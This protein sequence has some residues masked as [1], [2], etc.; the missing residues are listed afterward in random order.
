MKLLS[1]T[2][3]FILALAFTA[4]SHDDKASAITAEFESAD[5][6]ENAYFTGNKIELAS[7]TQPCQYISKAIMASMLSIP[8]EK[9]D[10]R[11]DTHTKRCAYTIIYDQEADKPD[12]TTASISLH[13]EVTGVESEWKD[14]WSA[15]KAISK[16]AE[17]VP[18]LGKAAI[19][20]GAS[21]QLDVKFDGY[22]LTVI[23]PRGPGK[24]ES[25]SKKWAIEMAKLA[26]FV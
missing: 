23:A 19:W 5:S 10:Y 14:N 20:K 8:V 9:V 16:S 25:K 26:G 13:Q 12:Y 1:Q 6:F 2:L 3:L 17:W 7:F 11:P 22:T 18:N 24:D 4:C 15:N 21:L